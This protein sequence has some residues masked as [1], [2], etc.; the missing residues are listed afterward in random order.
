MNSMSVSRAPRMSNSMLCNL[1]R[2]YAVFIN[3]EVRRQ[4]LIRFAT[5]NV[6]KYQDDY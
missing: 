3:L 4:L 6:T 5:S 2:C 1:R